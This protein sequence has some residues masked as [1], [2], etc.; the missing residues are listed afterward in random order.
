MNYITQQT[1]MHSPQYLK[2]FCHFSAQSVL[3]SMH[4]CNTVLALMLHYDSPFEHSTHTETWLPW[5]LVHSHI[6]T[7]YVIFQGPDRWQSDRA[8]FGLQ[9]GWGEHPSTHFD[10]HQSQAC[11]VKSFIVTLKDS[12]SSQG[13]YSKAMSQ[14]EHLDISSDTD[15]SSLGRK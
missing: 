14:L 4:L 3:Q 9:R 13:T 11:S 12:G 7:L 1:Y 2:M 10:S 6:A 8:K 15:G 5:L